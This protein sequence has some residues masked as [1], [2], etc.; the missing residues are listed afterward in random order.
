MNHRHAAIDLNTAHGQSAV[1]SQVL[2]YCAPLNIVS[3]A[4]MFTERGKIT[5]F[6]LRS[7][8]HAYALWPRVFLSAVVLATVRGLPISHFICYCAPRTVI[9]DV[10][11]YGRPPIVLIRTS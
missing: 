10:L 9:R 8:T 11:I 7:R 6:I 5:V 1:V 3:S 2:V 4:W